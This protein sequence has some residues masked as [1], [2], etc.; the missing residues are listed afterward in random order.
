[1]RVKSHGFTLLEILVSGFVLFLVISSTT[2][3]YRG[4]LLSSTKAEKAVSLSTAAHAIRRIITDDFHSGT[5][6]QK[7][8]GN[9]QYADVRFEWEAKLTHEGVPALF[10]MQESGR[11]GDLRYFLW[12]ISFTLRNRN[13]EKYYTFSEISW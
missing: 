9:G 5:E 2:S 13:F 4:A 7:V 10:L 8:N 3:I 12:E 11:G 1:M 6:V